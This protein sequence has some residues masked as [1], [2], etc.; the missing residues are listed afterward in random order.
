M[1]TAPSNLALHQ[2][3]ETPRRRLVKETLR[4]RPDRLIVGE[5]RDA[6]ALDLLL[7]LKTG[8]PH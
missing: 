4:M 1:N 2:T 6:E 7:A 5:V 8:A 3:G